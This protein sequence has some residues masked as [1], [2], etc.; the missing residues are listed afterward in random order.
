MGNRQFPG[1][2]ATADW[3]NRLLREREERRD[4]QN[5]RA[6]WGKGGGRDENK[7]RRDEKVEK[8]LCLLLVF[9]LVTGSFLSSSAVQK[10]RDSIS[11]NMTPGYLCDSTTL[12]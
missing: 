5:E 10:N 3:Y 7:G 1:A 6:T 4:E 2:M 12:V 11:L 9:Y 8:Q